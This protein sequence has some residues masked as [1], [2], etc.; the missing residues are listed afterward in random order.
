[1][2]ESV[3]RSAGHGVVIC[4]RSVAGSPSPGMTT[5]MTTR[6]GWGLGEEVFYLNLLDF[7]GTEPRTSSN[8]V[9]TSA[10]PNYHQGWM[11]TKP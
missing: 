2:W 3:S 4:S 11:D 6:L 9:L 7:K 8:G 1:M 10:L 5:R